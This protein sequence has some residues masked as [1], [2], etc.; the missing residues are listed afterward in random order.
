MSLQN[1]WFEKAWSRYMERREK[2]ERYRALYSY[3][4]ECE[5][6]DICNMI[7]MAMSITGMLDV[8]IER[9]KEDRWRF[10]MSFLVEPVVATSTTSDGSWMLSHKDWT[11]PNQLASSSN[12]N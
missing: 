1:V 9:H 5:S 8:R 2:I 12:S 10:K 3:T 4:E 11:K 6:R 7:M